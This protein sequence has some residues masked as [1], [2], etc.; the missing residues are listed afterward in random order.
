MTLPF[1][2]PENLGFDAERLA[3][4][5]TFFQS[6]VDS[7]RLSGVGVVVARQGKIAH[8]SFIGASAMDGGFKLDFDSIFRIYSMT[9]PIT[10]M[11]L[12]MLYERGLCQLYDPVSKFIPSFKDLTV[13][14][15]GT[16]RDFT[17]RETDREMTIHD[18]LTHQSGLTYDFMLASPVD[19]I[20]RNQ[21]VNGARSESLNLEELCDKLS[22]IPLVFSPGERWNYSVSTD[23]VGRIIEVISGKSLDEFM[24]EEIFAPLKMIDTSF[25]IADEKRA[26]LTHNYAKD[27]LSGETKL[28]DGPDK[29]IYSPGR[30]FL[31]GGGGLLSTIND[32]MRFTQLLH[33]GGSLDG[34]RL[35]SPHTLKMMRMNHLPNNETLMDRASGSFS[36][37]SY[38]GTGFGLGFSVVTDP[39]QTAT[40]SFAGNYSWGGMAST[41]FWNDPVNEI[42][43]IFM[44]QLMPSGTY[45]VRPQL[46]QLVYASLME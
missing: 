11:A 16:S 6:Y 37:V 41:F 12:M 38:G 32:Y 23:V 14:D 40:V 21:R 22:E 30:K 17:T 4:I 15:T 20:Y 3:K 2:N 35:L 44:T 28:V 26:R 8:S 27:P 10:S 7:G 45:P 18:L 34:V 31:S 24:Q 1:E 25:T 9:K 19:A 43:T 29:T 13:F 36:E 5:P 33:C 46:S 42:T 39:S